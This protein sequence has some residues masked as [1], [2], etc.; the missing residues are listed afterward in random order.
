MIRPMDGRQDAPQC[1]SAA[2]V[3]VTRWILSDVPVG[4]VRL[5]IPGKLMTQMLADLQRPHPFAAERVGFLSVGAG[6]G[7]DGE[8]IVIGR[9]YHAVRDHDYLRDDYVGARI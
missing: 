3:S 8:V 1:S 4:V 5:R 6:V 2:P 9:E 7:E